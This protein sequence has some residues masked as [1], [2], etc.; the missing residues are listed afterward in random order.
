VQKKQE[1]IIPLGSIATR[2]TEKSHC[3]LKGVRVSDHEMLVEAFCSLAPAPR[4]PEF[5]LYLQESELM[6]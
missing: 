6:D 4:S 1:K 3:A 2:G 5:S